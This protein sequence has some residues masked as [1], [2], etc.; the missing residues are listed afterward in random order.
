[1]RSSPSFRRVADLPDLAL[2]DD[3]ARLLRCSSATIRRRV[4][5]GV[6]PVLPLPGVDK[7]RRFSLAPVER[8]LDRGPC[9]ARCGVCDP[10][11]P[12]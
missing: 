7:R 8:Y 11:D 10:D 9:W 4:R 12:C 5:A 1:M 6:F 2:L 3:L